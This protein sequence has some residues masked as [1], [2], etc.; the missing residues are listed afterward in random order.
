MANALPGTKASRIHTWGLLFARTIPASIVLTNSQLPS[1][2]VTTAVLTHPKGTCTRRNFSRQNG[3]HRNGDIEGPGWSKYNNDGMYSNKWIQM[4]VP[5]SHACE[6]T[7]NDCL[8]EVL[9][10]ST[11]SQ[12]HPTCG[13]NRLLNDGGALYIIF[14]CLVSF[15]N[16]DIIWMWISIVHS[17]IHGLAC[18]LHI[19]IDKP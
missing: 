2:W 10:K 17:E 14:Y 8:L 6:N 19:F 9:S 4:T 12:E 16:L 18:C 5:S 13:K 11:K 1:Q 15:Q 3:R 7:Y